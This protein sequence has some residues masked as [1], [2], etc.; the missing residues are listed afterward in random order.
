MP[1]A[2]D[3]LHLKG[4]LSHTSVANY[5]N[6]FKLKFW[7]YDSQ[8][9][10]NILMSISQSAQVFRLICGFPESWIHFQQL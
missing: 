6:A 1:V 5:N 4:F 9:F 7:T 2:F 10:M 8:N 3:G